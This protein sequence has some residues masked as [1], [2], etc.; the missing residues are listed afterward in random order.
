MEDT[1]QTSMSVTQEKQDLLTTV[2]TLAQE[3]EQL[4]LYIDILK[5]HL[6]EKALNLGLGPKKVLSFFYPDF[7]QYLIFNCSTLHLG[8]CD[9]S[10]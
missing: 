9:N 4:K 5:S 8:S 1:L 2:H 6:D 7:L 3:N 10:I